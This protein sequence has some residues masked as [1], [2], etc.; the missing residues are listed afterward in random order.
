MSVRRTG[1]SLIE[2]VFVIVVV[3]IAA[4]AIG[5]A[6]AFISRTQALGLNLQTASQFAQE[7]A[8]HII[9][10]ARKPGSYAAVPVGGTACNAIAAPAGYNRTVVVAAVVGA[11]GTICTGAGWNCKSVAISV[12]RGSAIA[13][14]NFM[15]VNY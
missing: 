1:F 5:S 14:V 13:T 7:C 9:G 3:A 6:L 4:V 12:T 2:L 8:D 15:I 11:S 10:S